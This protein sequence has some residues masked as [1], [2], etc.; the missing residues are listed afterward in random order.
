MVSIVTENRMQSSSAV[1]DEDESAVDKVKRQFRELEKR[2]NKYFDD[3]DKVEE[4]CWKAKE[5]IKRFQLKA[6]A[7]K[8]MVKR[9][10][11]VQFKIYSS[12]QEMS[13]KLKRMEIKEKPNTEEEKL[14][15]MSEEA[16]RASQSTITGRVCHYVKIGCFLVVDALA[17][18]GMF[19]LTQ[20][21]FFG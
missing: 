14:P 11:D 18:Y 2:A 16:R 8:Q 5:D 10:R 9:D 12:L 4:M 1:P 21:V 13:H 17:A 6:E 19:K 20:P 3:L 7:D 15:V